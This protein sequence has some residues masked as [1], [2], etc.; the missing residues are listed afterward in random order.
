MIICSVQ[1]VD[2]RGHPGHVSVYDRDT[3]D[4]QLLTSHL[5]RGQFRALTLTFFS[6][7]PDHSKK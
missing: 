5:L 2:D 7:N 3:Q 1:A 6:F 4:K